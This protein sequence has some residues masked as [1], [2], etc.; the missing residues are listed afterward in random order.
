MV[1]PTY[2]ERNTSSLTDGG[3]STAGS[4]AWDDE[5]GAGSDQLFFVTS[6]S[7]FD[8]LGECCQR[9]FSV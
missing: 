1:N 8:K 3:Y 6:Y 9:F 2:F 5:M 4:T 7:D